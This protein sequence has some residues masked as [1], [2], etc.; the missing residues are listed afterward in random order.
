MLVVL[1]TFTC[2]GRFGCTVLLI[3]VALHV[4]MRVMRTPIFL[5]ED[6]GIH[7]YTAFLGILATE[8]DHLLFGGSSSLHVCLSS[9]TCLIS[10]EGLINA[11]KWF[12]QLVNTLGG[13]L[14]L[15]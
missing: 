11:L 1:H 7:I 6:A 2:K 15:P 8:R 10:Q 12:E 3:S 13:V 14:W 5:A 4:I 9:I